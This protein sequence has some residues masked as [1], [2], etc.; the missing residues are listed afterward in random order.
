MASFVE[1]WSV[2]CVI[3]ISDVHIVSSASDALHSQCYATSV[4]VVLCLKL[5]LCVVHVAVFGIFD[6][7][8]MLNIMR[9]KQVAYSGMKAKLLI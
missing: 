9:F 7:N 1:A 3:Q 6:V 2:T 8:D 4:I 5:V